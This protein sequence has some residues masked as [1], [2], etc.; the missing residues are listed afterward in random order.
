MV[1]LDVLLGRLLLAPLAR[2]DRLRSGRR[3]DGDGRRVA[4]E[5]DH[6]DRGSALD[7][8]RARDERR[9]CQ[10]RRVREARARALSGDWLF[11]VN[12]VRRLG[13]ECCTGFPVE[14]VT[15]IRAGSQRR[16]FE[17]LSRSENR[18]LLC[19]KSCL[20]RQRKG[21]RLTDGVRSEAANRSKAR[22]GKL[23]RAGALAESRAGRH[24]KRGDR[25]RSDIRS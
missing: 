14:V 8:E 3:G 11:D 13:A 1:L 25:H 16:E 7:R 20:V 22:V 18:Q 12:R 5:L 21:A 4:K 19:A 23:W 9:R 17:G 24:D 10:Q 15:E 6:V 2:L